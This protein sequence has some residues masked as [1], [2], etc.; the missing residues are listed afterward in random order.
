MEIKGAK[1][2]ANSVFSV[3]RGLFLS[4]KS[5]M[6]MTISANGQEIPVKTQGT[7][8]LVEGKKKF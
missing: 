5:S 4:Q 8:N 3:S 6:E 2:S 7:F 1:G